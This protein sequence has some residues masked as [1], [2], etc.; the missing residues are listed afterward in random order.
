M[1]TTPP[2]LDANALEA[3][4]LDLFHQIMDLE[5]ERVYLREEARLY[6][7]DRPGHTLAAVPGVLALQYAVTALIDEVDELHAAA[8][9]GSQ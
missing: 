1:D 6:L 3:W 5:A 7:A 9:G 2:G 4:A 8:D